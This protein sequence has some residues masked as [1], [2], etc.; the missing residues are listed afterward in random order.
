M[1][2]QDK[3]IQCSDCGTAFYFSAGEQ[4]FF[5]SKGYTN[6]PKRCP[7]CR[8]VRQA[9]RYGR[10]TYTLTSLCRNLLSIAL[11]CSSMPSHA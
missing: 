2:H 4:A 6:D 8:Q 5:E 11:R 10:D 9:D 3:Y 1:S 7:S